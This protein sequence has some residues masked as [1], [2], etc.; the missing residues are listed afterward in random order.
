M[1][2]QKLINRMFAGFVFVVSLIVYLKTI[3]PTTSFWDCGEF[4]TCS[5]ILGIP[6]PPGAPFYLLLGRIF[7]MLPIAADIGLRVNVISALSSSFTVM[8]LYLIIVRLIKQWRGEPKDVFDRVILVA[9]G[10]IGALAY[11]FSDTFWF[12]A[13]E[14]EVYA[15]S[16]FFASAIVW[17][18]L[19]WLE[20]ADKPGSER[21]LLIIAYL[22]GLAIAVHLLMILALP[23]IFLVIFF[24]YLDSHNR[25]VTFKKFATYIGV[26]LLVAIVVLAVGLSAGI[27]LKI[28]LVIIGVV[29][30]A[31]GYF[32]SD[33]KDEISFRIYM[34]FLVSTAVAFAAIYPGTVQYIPRLA[35]A[36]GYWVL[37][38]VILAV[39]AGIYLSLKNNYKVLTLSLMALLLIIT[40]Y[41]TYTMIYIR[42]NLDPA[43]DENDPETIKGMVSYLN[44]EQYGT[45]GTLPRRYQGLPPDWQ[46][47][48]ENKT[49]NYETYNFSKQM[50]F[51]W[52]Y[53]L[54]K[55][56]WRYFGWQFIGKGTTLGSDGFIAEFISLNGLWGLPFLIG[57][58]GMFH[59]FFKHWRHASFITLLFLLTGVAIVIYLNQEDPQPRER[60]YVYVGSYFAFAVWI[61]LG[62]TSVLE[63]L[64]ESM[65]QKVAL[66]N[67]LAIVFIA[68]FVLAVPINLIAH[69]Y[70][71]HDRTGN[72]VAYDYSY[73]ILQTCE[74]EAIVFTNGDNDTFPLWFLQYVYNIRPDV[75]VVNLSLL[76]TSWYIKQLKNQEPKVPISLKDDQVEKLEII[77]W[78]TREIAIPVPA[79]ARVEALKDLGEFISLEETEMLSDTTLKLRVEPTVFGQAIRI[80]D[81]MVLNIVS[82]NKWRKPI[83]FA[84]TVSDQNKVNFDDYLRMD[85]LSFKIVP[86]QVEKVNADKL[87]KNLT[88]VF[89]YRNLNNPDVYFNDNIIGLLQNYRAAFLRLAHVYF[90]ERQYDK[91]GAI[92][93]KME[94]AMPFKVIPAPD[95]RLPLQVGQYYS[96]AG[97]PEEFLRLAEFAYNEEPH[98]P[99]VVG[100]FITLLERE[101]QYDKALDVLEKWQAERPDDSEARKKIEELQA[102]KNQSEVN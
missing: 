70:K 66:R 85:G 30:I 32:S 21:Y 7:T 50:Q 76:N 19:V 24:K 18:I 98:N 64:K 40:G 89:Q 74:P 44:R 10:V 5:Y 33:K 93:E 73:N 6:H 9:S 11:A 45:W 8:F 29:L 54:N 61:G 56:Y 84:V 100:T 16:M 27:S 15:I 12:N 25:A 68:L 23:A 52:N 1:Q 62:V 99:E 69:N 71:D 39:L 91:L 67:A 14:A 35:G 86:Y 102:L 26:S 90:T 63:W 97:K 41:S 37:L 94:E 59:H 88:E 34:L 51:L 17:L 83:Y 60:D 78:K 20:K 82:A 46:F 65:A 43:V 77:P 28:N 4:I 92:L 80:Q 58:L 31:I 36:L 87:E 53:Q 57:L 3:A 2:K 101:K 79:R 22:V 38:L 55:M 47:Q 96:F 48:Y 72:Y 42:S 49:D 81:Y 13:V 95:V 75:R